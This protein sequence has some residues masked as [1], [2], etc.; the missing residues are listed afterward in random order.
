MLVKGMKRLWNEQ[1]GHVLADCAVPAI[2]VAVTG[3]G[4]HERLLSLWT[5]LAA[6]GGVLYVQMTSSML[7]GHPGVSQNQ[8]RSGHAPR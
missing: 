1:K 7:H 8:P 3:I 5:A 2:L 6:V 4:Y